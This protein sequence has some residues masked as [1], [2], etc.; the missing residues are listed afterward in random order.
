MILS[1]SGSGRAALDYY[2]RALS[3]W[4]EIGDRLRTAG[5]LN[6]MG[7]VC[8]FQGKP[9]ESLGHLQR[10]LELRREAGDRRL[11]AQ[12]LNNIGLSLQTMGRQ[13]EAL[14]SFQECVDL[15]GK[16]ESKTDQASGLFN[17]AETEV[18][19][20]RY[21]TALESFETAITLMEEMHNRHHLPTCLDG[22]ARAY[23]HLGE[24]ASAAASHV[25]ALEEARRLHDPVQEGF[26]LA[27]LAHDRF[28][29][30]EEAESKQ[31]LKDSE[32]IA[33]KLNHPRL[34]ARVLE[35][36]YRIARAR[37][38]RKTLLTTARQI[39]AIARETNL[40]EDRLLGMQARA[41]ALLAA[42]RWQDAEGVLAEAQGITRRLGRSEAEWE[43]VANL[44]RCAAGQGDDARAAKL[45]G[46]AAEII[47]RLAANIASVPMRERY[48]G[49]DERKQVLDW[50]GPAATA[51]VAAADA[52]PALSSPALL[53]LQD[54]TRTITSILSLD[55]LLERVMDLAIE[56]V[57]AERGILFLRDEAVG[58]MRIRVARNTEKETLGDATEYSSQVLKESEAGRSILAIDAGSDER[59][60]KFQSVSLYQIRSLMCVPLRHQDRILGTVYLDTR[61]ARK[62]FTEDDLRFL[63][64]FAGQAAIAIDNAALYS[65][66]EAENQYLRQS[67]EERFRYGSI[68]GKSAGMQQVFDLLDRLKDTALPVL[69]HGESGTGK[70]LVARALHHNSPRRNARFLTE[71]CAAM[72]ET[73][74]ES[75]L[76]GH[77]KGAFTG[78]DRA[79]EGLFLVA[80]GGTLFLDEIADM[81][82]AMQSKL[83]RAIQEGEIRP[84]GSN[85]MRKVDVRV[86]S[87]TNQPPQQL[88]AAGTLRQ[89]LY[90]RL[91]AVTIDLP[92]LRER[93]EDVP[94][95]VQHFLDRIAETNQRP[96]YQVTQEAMNLL[97][98][99]H[100][101]GN[102]RELEN[103]LSRLALF[104]D[105]RLT[106]KVLEKD[107]QT[108]E[109]LTGLEVP[110]GE[111]PTLEE[112]EK[113]HIL[114]VLDEVGGDRSL[115]ALRLGISR[116][117]IFRK[118]KQYRVE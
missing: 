92:P 45:F 62:A 18:L 44:G 4:E 7:L 56:L 48:L 26:A 14:R 58:D 24:I 75:E 114:Q 90:Y 39:E 65:R 51:A 63:E 31:L 21:D 25:R 99:Y 74:L 89:D 112:V 70:E 41:D 86:L 15:A 60:R 27:A 102:V 108:Y 35:S 68:I 3:L 69:I 30:G 107:R 13:E 16:V 55:E 38:S 110:P 28:R 12:S 101:P 36:R 71:N 79:K 118:L 19:L 81:N 52:G 104:A 17:Q 5:T 78:A 97:L 9:D 53:T 64:I 109:K 57:G 59:F 54:I 116:A 84:V 93:K 49:S 1:R 40:D 32:A 83:L 100:W 72:P 61:H 2:R 33:V 29:L 76:F 98:R 23:L 111:I 88:I 115:A 46:A 67:L 37:G 66:L 10:S 11:A 94:L 20:G 77:V 42:R 43:I 87:A 6:N 85:T 103:T 95:L 105:D 113:R 106:L 117:T 96:Q 8:L 91:S 50:S 22:M 82:P 80:D 47:R 73:L 34:R